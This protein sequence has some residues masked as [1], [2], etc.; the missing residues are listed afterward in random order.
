MRGDHQVS[1]GT[2]F[3]NAGRRSTEQSC[4]LSQREGTIRR[5]VRVLHNLTPLL[6]R[7]GDHDGSGF[8]HLVAQTSRPEAARVDSAITQTLRHRRR[9]PVPFEGAGAG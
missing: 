6:A 7:G 1:N 4:Q 8:D 3:L 5:I 2:R 9:H